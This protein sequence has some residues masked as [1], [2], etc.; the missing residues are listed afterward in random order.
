MKLATN[1]YNYE[2]YWEHHVI[3]DGSSYST[4]YILKNS[5][6]IIASGTY[7]HRVKHYNRKE[8][9]LQSFKIAISKCPL[10]VTREK[11]WD[12]FW[13]ERKQTVIV[14]PFTKDLLGCLKYFEYKLKDK[15]IFRDKKESKAWTNYSKSES[16][17]QLSK[18]LQNFRDTGSEH[19]LVTM[20]VESLIALINQKRKQ[21]G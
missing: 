18:T 19:S 3:A 7:T 13:K 5:A 11:F 2:V 6:V 8:G 20:A 14:T 9:V 16:V 17:V 4:C 15:I 12:A 21:N 10:R 1:D